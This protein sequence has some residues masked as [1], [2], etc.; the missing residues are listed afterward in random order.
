MTTINHIFKLREH[1]SHCFSDYIKKVVAVDIFSPHKSGIISVVLE[2]RLK[3]E[4]KI[5]IKNISLRHPTLTNPKEAALFFRGSFGFQDAENFQNS[6]QALAHV[7]QDTDVTPS[8]S[9][10]VLWRDFANQFKDWFD[11]HIRERLLVEG[12][13]SLTY[14]EE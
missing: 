11:S 7:L 10:S 9:G 12:N 6:L 2:I 14:F 3:P 5:E 8:Y 1:S 4:E 13:A